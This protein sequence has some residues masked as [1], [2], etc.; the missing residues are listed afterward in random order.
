MSLLSRKS[1]LFDVGLAK[2][3]RKLRVPTPWRAYWATP[4]WLRGLGYDN[5][6][7]RSSMALLHQRADLARFTLLPSRIS[8]LIRNQT[9]NPWR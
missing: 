5:H 3:W 4:C 6:C 7:P 9:V 8:F 1:G 2:I